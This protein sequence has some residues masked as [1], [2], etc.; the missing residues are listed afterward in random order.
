M[1]SGRS[2]LTCP[3]RCVLALA[4]LA[5]FASPVLSQSRYTVKDLG[6]LPGGALGASAGM[7]INNPGTVA[8]SRLLV[9]GSSAG[10][11]NSTLTTVL[12]FV[13]SQATGMY[14]ASGGLA[15][16]GVTND[17]NGAGWFCGQITVAGA[18]SL[19]TTGFLASFSTNAVIYLPSLGGAFS[20]AHALN[21]S[22]TVVGCSTTAQGVLR[23][24]L[25][26]SGPAGTPAP[27]DLGT[28]GGRTSEAHGITNT[29]WIVGWAD[30]A[31][32]VRRAFVSIPLNT[33]PTK[34]R[35]MCDLGALTNAGSSIARDAN[36]LGQIVGQSAFVAVDPTAAVRNTRAVLWAFVPGT[37]PRI[38][39]LGVLRNTDRTSEA[40]GINGR[41]QIVGWSGGSPVATSATPT[42]RA[43]LWEN[44]AMLDLN[45]LIPVTSGWQL[46]T[47][48]EINDAGLIV[49]WGLTRT[50]SN[51]HAVQRAF[52]LTPVAP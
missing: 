29:G 50:A 14:D 26:A 31:A 21:E 37:P 34:P 46:L 10:A 3:P 19:R 27:I 25:W 30:N 24:T 48:S 45:T 52:L 20:S 7:S 15:R 35:H 49:G 1:F 33:D 5:L 2:K 22:R 40:L 23:A 43:F 47:A 4:G 38:Q 36:G 13:W 28:L 12:P 11:A 44:G 32:N 16:S 6:T 42:A 8:T 9:V 41:S 18:N 17:V 51:T 39:N